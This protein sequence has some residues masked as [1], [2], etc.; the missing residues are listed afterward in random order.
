[1]SQG[2]QPDTTWTRKAILLLAQNCGTLPEIAQA[3][4]VLVRTLRILSLPQKLFHK[5]VQKFIPGKQP[6]KILQSS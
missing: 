1:M 3:F 4:Y 6:L 5:M 2:C